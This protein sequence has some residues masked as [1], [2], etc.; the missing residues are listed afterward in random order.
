MRII[1]LVFHL[2]WRDQM[3]VAGVPVFSQMV[4]KEVSA[5]QPIKHT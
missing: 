4:N 5:I 1:L 2:H 3:P